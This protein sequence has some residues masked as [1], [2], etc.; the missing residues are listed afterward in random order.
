M[1]EH[2]LELGPHDGRLPPHV[3]ADPGAVPQEADVAEL[4]DLV[5]TNRL[6]R[7][8]LRERR[9]VGGRSGHERDA[10]ARARDLDVDPNSTTLSSVPAARQRSIRFASTGGS[11]SKSCTA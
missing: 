3:R 4:V 6:H 5:G 9:E 10:R 1:V 2:P 7:K 8:E 11:S